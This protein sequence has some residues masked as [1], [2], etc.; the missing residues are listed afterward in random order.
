[1]NFGTKKKIFNQNLQKNIYIKAKKSLTLNETANIS[2]PDIDFFI[3]TNP[4]IINYQ[5][6]KVY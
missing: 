2:I 1:M 6:V 5:K 4:R 3:E